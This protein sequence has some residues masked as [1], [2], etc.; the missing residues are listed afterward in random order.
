MVMDLCLRLTLRLVYL[1]SRLCRYWSIGR[2]LLLWY[3]GL[4][5]L[6]VLRTMAGLS[7]PAILLCAVG[8]RKG[9]V[10]PLLSIFLKLL[11]IVLLSVMSVN[12]VSACYN[13]KTAEDHGVV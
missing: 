10:S 2:V 13:F 12:E 4:L 6:T 3:R 11:L 1:R 7:I 8:T 5:L 9:V